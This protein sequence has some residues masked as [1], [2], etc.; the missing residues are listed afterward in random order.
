MPAAI[1]RAS[2]TAIATPAPKARSRPTLVASPAQAFKQY[3]CGGYS[4]VGCDFVCVPVPVYPPRVPVELPP[5]PALPRSQNT[6]KRIS[7]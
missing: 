5:V 7:T 3:A 1:T 4:G 2:V 6:P